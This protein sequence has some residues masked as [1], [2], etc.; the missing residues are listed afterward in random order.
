MMIAV[1]RVGIAFL[2]DIFFSYSLVRISFPTVTTIL[3]YIDK[4][5]SLRNLRILRK[6]LKKWNLNSRIIPKIY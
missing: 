1:S 5:F 2:H 4:N 3:I 6:E